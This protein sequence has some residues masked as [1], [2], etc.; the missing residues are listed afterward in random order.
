MPVCGCIGKW[1]REMTGL[2]DDSFETGILAI[3]EAPF[4][5]LNL[6]IKAIIHVLFRCA[7]NFFSS[8][9]FFCP[10]FRAYYA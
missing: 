8:H 4:V 6:L 1:L 10:I 9:D 7:N 2:C 5:V 3:H